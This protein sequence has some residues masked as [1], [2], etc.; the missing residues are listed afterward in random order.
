M[1]DEVSLMTNTRSVPLLKEVV[2]YSGLE[3]PI[4][5][6]ETI[7]PSLNSPDGGVYQHEV[8]SNSSSS[9]PE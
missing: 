9:R 8:K 5:G 7:G 6:P 3:D 4:P 2:P 1:T